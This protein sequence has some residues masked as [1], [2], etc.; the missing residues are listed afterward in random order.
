M[1]HRTNYSHADTLFQ[2]LFL[3]SVAFRSRSIRRLLLDLYPHG[4]NDSGGMFQ[5]F[6]KQVPRNWLAVIF[7]YRVKGGN[8]QHG[9]G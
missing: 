4:G 5:L 7:R 3:F 8:F 1:C 9:G 6:Y 2:E